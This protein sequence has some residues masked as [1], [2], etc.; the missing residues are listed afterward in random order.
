MP[1]FHFWCLSSEGNAT[2]LKEASFDSALLPP[3]ASR[4][5]RHRLHSAEAQRPAYGLGLHL[6]SDK[7]P[8]EETMLSGF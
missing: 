7:P 1:F 6:F 2:D 8:V 5:R 4:R 3:L